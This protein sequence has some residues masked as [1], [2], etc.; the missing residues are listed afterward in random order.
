MRLVTRLFVNSSPYLN[1]PA[2]QDQESLPHA[3]ENHTQL[4]GTSLEHRN[5]AMPHQLS[6]GEQQRVALTRALV[7]RPSILLMDEP[8]SSLDDERKRAIAT[9]L[10]SLQSQFD[11][12]GDFSGRTTISK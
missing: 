10:L 4:T 3:A 8:L 11:F 1:A 9:D 6:G 2:S 5:N 7:F 12:S